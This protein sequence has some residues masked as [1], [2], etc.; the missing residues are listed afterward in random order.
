MRILS[1]NTFFVFFFF[2]FWGGCVK[3]D[4]VLE[5]SERFVSLDILQD[6]L[7]ETYNRLVETDARI[8]ELED[9]ISDLKRQIKNSN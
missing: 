9:E 2:F 4:F 5:S 6:E 7:I 3:E 8:K 1:E